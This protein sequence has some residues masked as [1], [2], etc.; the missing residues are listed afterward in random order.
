MPDGKKTVPPARLV[1]CA[2]LANKP[3]KKASRYKVNPDS[4]ASQQLP[5]PA[6]DRLYTLHSF[7]SGTKDQPRKGRLLAYR[8]AYA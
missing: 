2:D 7:V 5:K 4:K 3:M 8:F 6:T 1:N